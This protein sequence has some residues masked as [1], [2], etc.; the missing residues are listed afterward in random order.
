MGIHF[1]AACSSWVQRSILKYTMIQW[2]PSLH[3]YMWIYG[4]INSHIL[5]NYFYIH[6]HNL[7]QK[8]CDR[9]YK[10]LIS[11]LLNG[12]RQY[13]NQRSRWRRPQKQRLLHLFLDQR[14]EFDNSGHLSSKI[15]DKR[16]DFSFM[17]FPSLYSNTP[18]SPA[19]G[20]YIPQMIC[21]TEASTNYSD[22]LERHKYLCNRL[23]NQGYQK[24]HLKRSLTKLNF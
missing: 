2:D 9:R 21:Y 12:Y 22:F 3:A 24:M 6:F 8:D 23:L 1:L 13:T 17:N 7:T 18:S 11:Y 16:D 5:C 19:Y 10:A 14:F 20:L 15:Y 4:E